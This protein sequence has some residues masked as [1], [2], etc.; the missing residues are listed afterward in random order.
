MRHLACIIGSVLLLSGCNKGPE[1]H[2]TNATA[3]EVATKVRA[4]AAGQEMIRPGEW[5]SDTTVEEFSVPG[6]PPQF[7]DRM[8]KAMASS[9]MH[10]FKTCVTEADVK[11]PK[12][13]F[14]AGK[15]NNCRYDH[16]DM[17][18]GKIDAVM[19]CSAKDGQQKM[20]LTGT[21]S[22]ESYDIHMQM[23]GQAE[24]LG[25]T[26]SMKSH[27]VSHR[28]GECTGHEDD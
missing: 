2:A 25:G 12:E 15:R 26:M 8:K 22:P 28:I 10:S 1:V 14:F 18:G 13:D 23:T 6:M 19:N 17:G 7:Q 9:Q 24:G 27:T 20:S 4:A 21:Y 11:K 5:E 3:N 16:F